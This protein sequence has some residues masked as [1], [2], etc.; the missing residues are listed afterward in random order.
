[1]MKCVGCE[2]L[3][4]VVTCTGR[5]RC[6]HTTLEHGT[7]VSDCPFRLR[8]GLDFRFWRESLIDS[9]FEGF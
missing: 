3:T 8:C 5:P 4:V 6:A 2:V 9:A 7:C 1:M